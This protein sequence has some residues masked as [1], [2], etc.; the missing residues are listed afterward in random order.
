MKDQFLKASGDKDVFDYRGRDANGNTLRWEANCPTSQ[1][2]GPSVSKHQA[3]IIIYCCREGPLYATKIR[4]RLAQGN[5]EQAQRLN[6]LALR[7][8]IAI[9]S[10][11]E[12]V[13]AGVARLLRQTYDD[14]MHIRNAAKMKQLAVDFLSHLNEHGWLK[15]QNQCDFN[16]W[17]GPAQD[18]HLDHRLHDG[19]ALLGEVVLNHGEHTA[20]IHPTHADLCKRIPVKIMASRIHGAQGPNT[21]C[22]MEI[23]ASRGFAAVH[24]ARQELLQQAQSSLNLVLAKGPDRVAGL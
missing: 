14:P 8:V 6:L 3:T 12:R 5:D 1:P 7:V 23:G 17:M 10:D 20:G 15:D 19:Q 18:F 24:V 21:S 22:V 4:V 9:Y 13:G 16:P 11:E 2:G